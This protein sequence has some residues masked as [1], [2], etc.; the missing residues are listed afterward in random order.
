MTLTCLILAAQIYDADTLRCANQRVRLTGLD[1]PELAQVCEDTPCG[2]ISR[3]ALRRLLN[4]K[5]VTCIISGTDKYG[6]SLGDCWLDMLDITMHGWWSMAMPSR[7]MAMSISHRC[8]MP[9]SINA[10]SGGIGLSY[11]VS[12]GKNMCGEPI[13]EENAAKKLA[14]DVLKKLKVLLN[15]DE[16]QNFIGRDWK[17]ICILAHATHQAYENDQRYKL[18]KS[19]RDELARLKKKYE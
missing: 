12:G 5:Q 6:R 8:S 15:P 10:E 4:G 3:D 18:E 9:C 14:E 16:L 13:S 2:I 1:A 11:R 17:R 19:E 7:I